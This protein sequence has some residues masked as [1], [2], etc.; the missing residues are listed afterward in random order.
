MLCM[1]T[2]TRED[3]LAGVMACGVFA[4]HSGCT[5]VPR[6]LHKCPEYTQAAQVPREHSGCTGIPRTPHNY[7]E[8]T[9][10]LSREHCTNYSIL[11]YTSSQSQNQTSATQQTASQSQR[12]KPHHSLNAANRITVSTQQTASQSQRA[13][14]WC[15]SLPRFLGCGGGRTRRRECH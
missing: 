1:W 8:N 9:A 11:L 13:A 10:Q 15:R 3:D 14:P 7:P 4:G 6:T 5:S 2:S 12:S